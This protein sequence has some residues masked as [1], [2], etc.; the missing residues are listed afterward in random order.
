MSIEKNDSGLLMCLIIFVAVFCMILTGTIS[1]SLTQTII[2]AYVYTIIFVLAVLMSKRVNAL[3]AGMMILYYSLI[4]GIGIPLA[5]IFSRAYA[6][7]QINRSLYFY[8]HY[9][10]RYV[11]LTLL[12]VSVMLIGIMI[13]GRRDIDSYVEMKTDA[14]EVLHKKIFFVIGFVALCFFAMFMFLNLLTGNIIFGDYGAY[15]EWSGTRIRNYSQICFW[16]SSVL[17]CACGSKKQI[18][19]SLVIFFI[20]AVILFLSGNRNDVFFPLLIGIGLYSLRYKKVPT[21]I[22]VASII[23]V[24]I[25]GPLVVQLR[26]G[27]AVSI[28]SVFQN[29]SEGVAESF[30]ELGGELHA[31]SNMFTWLEGGES[32]A[33]GATVVIGLGASLFGKIFPS[34]VAYFEASRFYIPERV[35]SLGFT[36]S[37]EVFYNFSIIGVIIIFFIIGSFIGK[38][39]SKV[40]NLNGVIWYGFFMLWMLIL[41]RNSFGY[42]VVYLKVFIVLFILERIVFSCICKRKILKRKKCL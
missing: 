37:A 2:L 21:T 9:L 34:I 41:T 14:F 25:F 20:P 15:K 11:A 36:I 3:S 32:Y 23:T 1:L 12:S 29:I 42:S 28:D 39:E 30:Y 35:P 33:L 18:G 17:I 22:L 19:M 8:G 10:D 26:N 24:F 40:H 27:G 7:E 6:L 4:E 13:F 38:S 31:V 16:I 5:F